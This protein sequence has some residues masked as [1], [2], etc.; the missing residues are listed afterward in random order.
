M[1]DSD[2]TPRSERSHGSLLENRHYAAA[3]ES[4]AQEKIE[5]EQDERI[6]RGSI[7]GK[8]EE[9]PKE[10][11]LMYNGKE[12]LWRPR[13]SPEKPLKKVKDKGAR[14]TKAKPSTFLCVSFSRCK[15]EQ[16]PLTALSCGVVRAAPF[17][18]APQAFLRGRSTARTSVLALPNPHRHTHT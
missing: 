2:A 13:W 4:R 11:P 9:E 5:A 6:H 1:E 12:I 8:E 18:G 17:H 10:A 7:H 16:G 15:S 14:L 3:L